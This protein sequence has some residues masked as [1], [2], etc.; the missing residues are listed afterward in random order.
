[1]WLKIN[2]LLCRVIQRKKRKILWHFNNLF[3]IYLQ[4]ITLIW[5]EQKFVIFQTYLENI[6]KI[7]AFYK[8]IFLSRNICFYNKKIT[9]S[10]SCIKTNIIKWYAIKKFVLLFF[11]FLENCINKYKII[12]YDLQKIC[13]LW[14]VFFLIYD[15]EC[16]ILLCFIFDTN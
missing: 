5:F 14:L 2:I 12:H 4:E 16:V 8:E 10:L 13:I 3:S 9:G 7:N 1:M 15:A 6:I 11:L